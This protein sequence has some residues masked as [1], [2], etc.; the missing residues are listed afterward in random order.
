M[1]SN[2]RRLDMHYLRLHFWQW[3]CCQTLNFI[4]AL[5]SA[6]IAALLGPTLLA[7]HRST[8]QQ[9][10][11][12]TELF[13]AFW[14]RIFG[15]F[16]IPE[17]IEISWLLHKLPIVL[18]VVATLKLAA[19]AFQNIIWEGAS[20]SVAWKLRQRLFEGFVRSDDGTSG[21]QNDVSSELAGILANDVR[22]FREY[23]VHFFGS[24]PRELTQLSIYFILLLTYSPIMTA[25]FF[26]GVLPVIAVVAR[27]GKKLRRRAEAVLSDFSVLAEWIQIRLLG[28]ET[29]KH[30]QS[31]KIE[32][33]K[34]L[35]RSNQLMHTMSRAL[36]VKARSGP[37]MELVAIFA[38]CAVFYFA[39]RMV[40]NGET[41][42]AVQMSFFATLALISQAGGRMGKY[43]N[44]NREG[45]AAM[46]RIAALDGH[47]SHGRR[48]KLNNTH[49]H[50]AVLSVREVCFRYPGQNRDA[51]S[52]FSY[53][54]STGKIYCL[55]GSSGSGKSTLF[56]LFLGL[57]APSSGTLSFA[58]G[59][60]L[61]FVPQRT[62][63]APVSI[64]RNIAYPD[65]IFDL[66]RLTEATEAVGLTGW[67][68]SL[69]NGVESEIGTDSH[70]VSGGQAQRISLA[71]IWYHG[72]VLAM[73]DEGTSAADPETE[74]LLIKSLKALAARGCCVITI[75]HRPA[76]AEAADEILILQDGVLNLSGAQNEVRNSKEF[77]TIFG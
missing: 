53:E 42:G 40:Q 2:L 41:N 76:V 44:Y 60:S 35:E 31:E 46:D 72:F 7:M 64:A 16:G 69:E 5:T 75:A 52:E 6:F 22:Q 26:A 71:R 51:V 48:V 36:R 9:S 14:S 63:L 54:F 67:I 4:L 24:L 18:I 30:F 27:L 39:F 21:R 3:I 73:I 74:R 59:V 66:A 34:M 70:G 61:G 43:L 10:A 49:S 20:E 58:S 29:I 68:N 13:G 55:V 19:A 8:E 37:A 57:E 12:L 28:I 65:Q 56:K 1:R 17:T 50:A 15:Y 32:S 25:V 11:S 62:N 23:F 38:V 45:V 47:L 77:R 33:A